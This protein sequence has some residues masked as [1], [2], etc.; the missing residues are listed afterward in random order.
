MNISLDE[1]IKL[2]ITEKNKKV[3]EHKNDPG[4]IELVKK[5]PKDKL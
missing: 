3:E 5:L 2:L 4:V 1:L